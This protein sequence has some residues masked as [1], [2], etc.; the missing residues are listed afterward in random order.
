MDALT[1]RQPWAAMIVNGQKTVENR[2]WR[3]PHRGP[4]LI[5]A[6]GR[7]DR[8]GPALD[9]SVPLG[10][11]VGIVDLVDI[12]RDCGREWAE[13]GCWHWLLVNPRLLAEPIPV[14]GSLRLWRPEQR[15]LDAVR[16]QL[17]G[18]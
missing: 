9:D 10:A 11:V 16:I 7:L 1:I 15:V 13:P 5:H 3:T 8:S 2:V 18:A 17:G 4:L 6:G 12:V 14:R